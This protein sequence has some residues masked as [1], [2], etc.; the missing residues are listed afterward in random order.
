MKN[1]KVLLA[2]ALMGV[3][4]AAM[5]QA[6]YT[7]SEEN[8]YTFQKHWFLDLQGGVLSTPSARLSLVI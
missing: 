8:V 2:A 4:S 7:D 5:A 6:T 3:S 1:S